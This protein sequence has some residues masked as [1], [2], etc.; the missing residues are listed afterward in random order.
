MTSYEWKRQRMH[1]YH[2]DT[3]NNDEWWK[4]IKRHLQMKMEIEMENEISNNST[5]Q[6]LPI[7]SFFL[8]QKKYFWKNEKREND[9]EQK[10]SIIEMIFK[11]QYLPHLCIKVFRQ[12]GSH[13]CTRKV[14]SYEHRLKAR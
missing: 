6:N 10:E 9:N 12:I 11:E 3:I 2:N 5:R 13:Q 8:I 1:S 7:F 14:R 4:W